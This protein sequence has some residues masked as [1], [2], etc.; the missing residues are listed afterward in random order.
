MPNQAF[1]LNTGHPAT[2]FYYSHY[3]QFPVGQR[4]GAGAGSGAGAN[5]AFGRPS[6]QGIPFFAGGNGVILPINP[7]G[8]N[9][10][11]GQGLGGQGLG[12]LG[13]GINQP[14]APGISVMQ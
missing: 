9:P 14:L 5:S 4:G 8:A 3:Y 13:F 11:G 2:Y 10:I 6:S 7:A 12:G 1:G